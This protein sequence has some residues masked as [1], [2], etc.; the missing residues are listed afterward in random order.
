MAKYSLQKK[1]FALSLLLM[2][3]PLVLFTAFNIATATRKVEESFRSSLVFGMKKVGSVVSTMFDDV[4]RTSLFI[5]GNREIMGFLLNEKEGQPAYEISI[6]MGEVYN[7]LIYLKNTNRAIQSIQVAASNGR[8]LSCG[9]F[10]Q[11]ITQED[12]SHATQLHGKSFWEVDYGTGLAPGSGEKNIY[13]GRLLRDPNGVFDAVGMVKIYL[14]NT[15]L[16]ELFTGE[17]AANTSYF[18]MNPSGK[19][20]FSTIPEGGP[21]LLEIP[22]DYDTLVQHQGESFLISS[23]DGE[24][25]YVAPYVLEENGWAVCSVSVPVEIRGQ[26]W[27]TLLQ[28]LILVGLCFLF[29]YSIARI[30]SR[31]LSRPLEDIVSHMKRLEDQDFSTRVAVQ[32]NDEISVLARQFNRMT[33]KIQSLVEEVYLAAIHRKELELR[34]LQAQVNP[35]FLYNTLDTIYWSAQMEHASETSDMIGSLSQFF[36]RALAGGSEFTSLENEIEHLRYYVIL[37]QQSKRPF[38]FD[39]ESDESLLS[40][41]VI[42]LVLQP[43]VE[44][45]VLHG[46]RDIERGSIRVKIYAQDGDIVYTVTDNGKGLE[47]A[48]MDHLLEET[49]KDNRGFGIKNINDRIQLV[50][51]K[52]YGLRFE[53]VSTGGAKITVVQ[54]RR[55]E[56]AHDKADGGG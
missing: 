12:W 21:S 42:K 36:R 32:G 47:L 6:T 18:L 19:I 22:I 30:I 53:N 10:P 37:R 45:A 28:L 5:L 43:L 49:E 48:D 11:N 34:A 16:T 39:L 56:E 8:A 44:N 26:I 31:R 40:C 17:E 27:G 29:C 20:Q 38:D 55:E 24:Q 23:G 9:F 41:R 1:I 54:P 15:V 51:G 3:I 13:Q 50:Y 2:L 7:G 33:E 46:I 14:D 52:E 25:F 35:H 4:D